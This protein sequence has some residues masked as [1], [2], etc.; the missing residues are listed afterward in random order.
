M[1]VLKRVCASILIAALLTVYSS[2]HPGRT[3]SRGGHTNHSTG[4][5]HYHHGYPAHDHL[6]GVCPY[7]SDTKTE[8]AATSSDGSSSTK[9]TSTKSSSTSADKLGS[10][11]NGEIVVIAL[12]VVFYILPLIGVVIEAI[13]DQRKRKKRKGKNE[14]TRR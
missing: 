8:T 6:G 7:S 2:A 14:G 12:V 10:S 9:T 11:K 1:R 5:Y 3:D 4:E 13:S